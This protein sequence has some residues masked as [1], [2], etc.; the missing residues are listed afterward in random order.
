MRQRRKKGPVPG[1]DRAA[2]SAGPAKSPP[3]RATGNSKYAGA[4]GAAT[5]PHASDSSL[6]HASDFTFKKKAGWAAI[7]LII[8]GA[9]GAWGHFDFSNMMGYYDLLADAFLKGQLHID[10]RPGEMYVHDMIPFEGRYYL[11]WGPVP[12]LFHMAA[13]SISLTLSDRVACLLIAWLTTLVFWRIISILGRRYFPELP[14]GLYPWFVMAFG[15]STTTAVIGLRGTVYHESIGMAALGV[16]LAV[17]GLLRYLERSSWVWALVAGLGIGVAVGS[18]IPLALYGIGLGCGLLAVQLLRR[19][20]IST[21]VAH[22][23]AYSIPILVSGGLLLA[24]NQARFGSPWDYGADYLV[25][26]VEGLNAFDLGRV[27]ENI[28]HYL[29]ALPQLTTDFPWIGH[30]GWPPAEKVTRLEDVSSIFL[31]SPF[32]LLAVLSW[33]LLGWKMPRSKKG[34]ENGLP[35]FTVSLAVSSG[36]AFFAILCFAAAARRYAH[37]FVPVW[38]VLAFIGAGLHRHRIATLWS[39]WRGPAWATVAVCALLHMHLS[40]TQSFEWDPP[41][42]NVMKSFVAASPAARR[43][44]PIG[45]NWNEKE[46]IIR[47]DMGTY[48]LNSGQAG[49]ALEHF[50][51]ANRLMPNEPRIEQNLALAKRRAAMRHG[52]GPR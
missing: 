27:L 32:L 9:V 39:R 16:M 3:I 47:N 20:S 49:E 46:A 35:L 51:W 50:E 44:M 38:M 31:I 52:G 33:P 6:P 43:F 30:V 7:L 26:A 23:T 25:D 40:F 48:L 11:Q 15:L 22:L 1:G 17:L 28:R 13:K 18:R 42:L 10:I 37:D 29:L 19:H 2:K 41:D 36:L 12:A 45:P 24:Y 34:A 21:A 8:Y 5:A 14:S 4:A